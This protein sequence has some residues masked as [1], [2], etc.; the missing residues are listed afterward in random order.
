VTY[1]F[2]EGII[3]WKSREEIE[4]KIE[5]HENDGYLVNNNDKQIKGSDGGKTGGGADTKC[6]WEGKTRAPPESIN[7]DI[8]MMSSAGV[9]ALREVKGSYSV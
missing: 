7:S 3:R 6:L 4:I 5:I 8:A 2:C 1:I 9:P